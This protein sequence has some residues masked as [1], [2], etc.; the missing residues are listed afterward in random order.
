MD[1]TIEYE[2]APLPT[3]GMPQAHE[4]ELGKDHK[5][6][7]MFSTEAEVSAAADLEDDVPT[8]EEMKTLKR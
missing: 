4:H 2:S 3:S 1:T 7:H 6:A 5:S 8:E